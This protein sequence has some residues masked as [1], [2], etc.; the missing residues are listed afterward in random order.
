MSHHKHCY[1]KRICQLSF[2]RRGTNASRKPL[3]KRSTRWLRGIKSSKLSSLSM[4]GIRRLS[5]LVCIPF[6]FWKYWYYHLIDIK[7]K[8]SCWAIFLFCLPWNFKTCL[9]GNITIYGSDLAFLFKLDSTDSPF[10][11]CKFIKL[12]SICA[13]RHWIVW[14]VNMSLVSCTEGCFNHL[15]FIAN[16]I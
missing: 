5:N 8:K 1:F 16:S 10:S 9:M 6:V 15:C 12:H 11:V 7:H 13:A 4:T 3:L 2:H 14:H